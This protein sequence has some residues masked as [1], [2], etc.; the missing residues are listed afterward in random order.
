MASNNSAGKTPKLK[1]ALL[2]FGSVVLG[3]AVF[4]GIGFV[5]HHEG[6]PQQPAARLAAKIDSVAAERQR[7]TTRLNDMNFSGTVLIVTNGHQH[8]AVS[9]GYADKPTRRKNTPQTAYEIDSL[10]KALTATLIMRE[11]DA[12]RLNLTDHLAKYYPQV[13]GAKDITLRDMLDM[14]SGLSVKKFLPPE[15]TTD[16][17]VVQTYIQ[18]VGY[19]KSRH[20][21]WWYQPVNYNLLSGIIA[22]V[23]QRPYADNLTDHVLNPL[24]LRHTHF[25]YLPDA[26]DATGYRWNSKQKQ[27]NYVSPYR[28]TAAQ[29]HFELGTGQLF[30]TPMDLYTADRAVIDGKLLGTYASD[31]LHKPGSPSHYGGGIYNG[32]QFMYA[33]GYGYGFTTFMRISKNGRNAVIVMANTDDPHGQNKY[34]AAQLTQ[35]YVN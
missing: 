27:P 20:G 12:G 10:Q 30:M 3:L 26:A 34:L 16:T 24:H 18:R 29:Q 8:L 14:K 35:Q 21:R 2:Q 15:Y 33:N 5:L 7:L 17:Q 11:V 1:S 23:S 13:P 22:Q 6:G 28:T 9:R 31:I 25:A 19:T 32:P 4:I